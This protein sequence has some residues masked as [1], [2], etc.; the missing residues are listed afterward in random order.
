VNLG[1]GVGEI[2]ILDRVVPVHTC[3]LGIKDL[4]EH[5]LTRK[6]EPK[7][8]GEPGDE[9]DRQQCEPII[10]VPWSDV[11]PWLMT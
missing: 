1:R 6:T 11:P 7:D 5:E 2:A 10:G 9:G 4:V 3:V 8:P